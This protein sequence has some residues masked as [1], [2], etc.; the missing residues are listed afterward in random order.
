MPMPLLELYA[1]L[2]LVGTVASAVKRPLSTL[3]M[4]VYQIPRSILRGLKLPIDVLKTPLKL[5]LSDR[6]ATAASAGA[7][8]AL[9]YL[10]HHDHTVKAN[11]NKLNK[12][13]RKAVHG[14]AR[15][16]I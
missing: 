11:V 13:I 8:A 12:T 6:T 1:P 10:Y 3:L 5:V 2:V 9:V 4:P 14:R 15:S 7:H 16:H